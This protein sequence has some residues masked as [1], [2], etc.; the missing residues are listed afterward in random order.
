M[1]DKIEVET[2]GEFMLIDPSNGQEI[3][4]GK[5]VKVEQTDFINQKIEQGQLRSAAIVPGRGTPD[6]GPSADSGGALLSDSMT[7][8]SAPPAAEGAR[9]GKGNK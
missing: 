2:T 8:A 4:P 3:E 5:K 9:R 7:A 1:T 6:E